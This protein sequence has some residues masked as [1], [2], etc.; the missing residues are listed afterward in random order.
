MRLRIRGEVMAGTDRWIRGI[1]AVSLAALLVPVVL[2]A[3]REAPWP[4]VDH[5]Q[6]TPAVKAFIASRVKQSFATPRTPWGGPDIQ[7]NFTTKDESNT[8]FERPDVW[9]GRKFDSITGKEFAEAVAKRQES[10][11]ENLV[12][13]GGGE[14]ENGVAIAVPIDWFDNFA[15]RNSRPWFVIDSVD[16]KILPK[17]PTAQDRPKPVN[18]GGAIKQA[19]SSLQR[20]LADRAILYEGP[21]KTPLFYDAAFGILL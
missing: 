21:N 11:A 15:A 8:P 10:A 14:P 16:G 5:L 13:A 18:A 6:G 1:G 2:G 12:F 19:D 9:K 3:E 7:G 4:D 17:I 20:S